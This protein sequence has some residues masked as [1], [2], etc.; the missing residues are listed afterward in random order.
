MP[1]VRRLGHETMMTLG[2]FFTGIAVWG[3]MAVAGPVLS[4]YL[5]GRSYI[6][7]VVRKGRED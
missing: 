3:V 2:Y 6:E 7:E 1:H 4:A 5:I